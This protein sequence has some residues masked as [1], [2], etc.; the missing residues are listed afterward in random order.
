LGY[1]VCSGKVVLVGGIKGRGISGDAYE[2]RPRKG[3][4]RQ[5]LRAAASNVLLASLAQHVSEHLF[6]KHPLI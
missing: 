6:A 4:G 2:S 5:V 1:W 3:R